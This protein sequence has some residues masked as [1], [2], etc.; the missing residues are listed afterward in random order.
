[1]SKTLYLYYTPLYIVVNNPIKSLLTP[2]RVVLKGTSP[3][4]PGDNSNRLRLKMTYT[5]LN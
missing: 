5:V 2:N 4:I 1:M 3:L